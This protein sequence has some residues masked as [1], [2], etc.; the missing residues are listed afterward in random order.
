MSSPRATGHSHRA[1]RLLTMS[2][3]LLL[4]FIHFLWRTE[5]FFMRTECDLWGVLPACPSPIPAWLTHT[6]HAHICTKIHKC[7]RHASFT[8]HCIFSCFCTAIQHLFEWALRENNAV[9]CMK[10]RLKP[11]SLNV[12]CAPVKFNADTA[13]IVLHSRQLLSRVWSSWF[14]TFWCDKH[15]HKL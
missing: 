13:E 5:R 4:F 1:A 7:R 14:K 15:R 11:F 2:R 3:R 10:F 8:C 6:T 12:R 9:Q